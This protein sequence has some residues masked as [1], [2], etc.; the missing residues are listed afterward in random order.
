MQVPAFTTG[1]LEQCALANCI[2]KKHLQER[3]VKEILVETRQ[4]FDIGGVDSFDYTRKLF[5]ELEY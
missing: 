3:R 5:C 2:G 1:D 4:L